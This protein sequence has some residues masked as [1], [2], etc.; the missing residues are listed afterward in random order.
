V[1]A[2]DL[3][4]FSLVA[5]V[6]PQPT[7]GHDAMKRSEEMPGLM[8][9]HAIQW[10]CP[11]CWKY[12]THEPRHLWAPLFRSL[13]ITPTSG[14]F[15]DGGAA[16]DMVDGDWAL[17]ANF[18]VLAFETRSNCIKH[19]HGTYSRE[20]ARASTSGWPSPAALR[21]LPN[22]LSNLTGVTISLFKT[23]DS[24]STQLSA[25]DRPGS[26]EREGF[27]GKDGKGRSVEVQTVRLDDAIGDRAVAA[28]K[29][30]IQG[31]EIDALLGAHK[32]LSRPAGRAP[33][34]EFEYYAHFR[35]DLPGYEILHLLR[36]YGYMCAF[37]GFPGGNPLRLIS[38]TYGPVRHLA[39]R[40]KG[41]P[42]HEIIRPPF[43]IPL[44]AS[45]AVAHGISTDFVCVKHSNKEYAE[46][47]Q[48]QSKRAHTIEASLDSLR[49]LEK[50]TMVEPSQKAGKVK[51]AKTM[52]SAKITRADSAR[53]RV[54][55]KKGFFS[56]W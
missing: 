34:V 37:L 32:L 6:T 4:I 16:C 11:D 36:G 15:V 14:I 10:L 42:K 12:G 43:D 13:D 55:K 41:D 1:Y 54:Q 28:L 46:L 9:A 56:F 45:G 19:L 51:T 8:T 26:I 3:L 50:L 39:R 22:A 29:L 33:L 31:A 40:I 24:S 38:K 2:R 49:A 18:S 48:E 17:S 20:L 35:P 23:G 53:I 27:R 44:S 5:K 47:I 25:V 21:L 52:N 7:D 30:D